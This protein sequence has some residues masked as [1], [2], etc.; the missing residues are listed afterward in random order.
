VTE[1]GTFN[2]R[3]RADTTQ[4]AGP[5]TAFDDWLH[6]H[7]VAADVVSD[8]TIVFSELTSNAVAS[9]RSPTEQVEARAEMLGDDVIIEVENA[10]SDRTFSLD[11]LG[12][13]DDPLRGSGRGLMIVAAFVD[14]VAVS[15]PTDS[16]G[17]TV[18]CRRTVVENRTASR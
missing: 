9:A 14:N 18:R 7:G 12:E 4:L 17:F 2:R 8:L 13:I 10:R 15:A 5:R 6:A 11:M 16:R 3:F 1:D